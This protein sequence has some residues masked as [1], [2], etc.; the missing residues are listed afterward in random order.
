[1]KY[2]KASTMSTSL[3]GDTIVAPDPRVKVT[4]A[5]RQQSSGRTQVDGN[6]TVLMPLQHELC[7]SRLGIPKLHAPVLASTGDPLTVGRTRDAEHVVLVP[8]KRRC[9]IGVSLF[10][11]AV[12]R[13][14]LDVPLRSHSL[15][16][17]SSDPETN[18]LPSGAKETE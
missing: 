15:S 4:T 9:A 18:D 7:L 14:G 8:Y 6:H 12:L 3:V 10:V 5:R 11:G 17:L 13:N 16:V 1:M 2:Y